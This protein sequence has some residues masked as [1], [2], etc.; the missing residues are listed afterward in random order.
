MGRFAVG[1]R[2][3]PEPGPGRSQQRDGAA[4]AKHLVIGMGGQHQHA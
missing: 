4:H 3:Q 2:D 1:H